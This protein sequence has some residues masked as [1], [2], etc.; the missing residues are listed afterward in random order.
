MARLTD[1][2]TS[3][4]VAS[5]SQL[6]PLRSKIHI[7]RFRS[8]EKEPPHT[9]FQRMCPK[10]NAP[11]A[12]KRRRSTPLSMMRSNKTS[13]ISELITAG[14]VLCKL[15][16]AQVFA[17]GDHV[18]RIC[19]CQIKPSRSEIVDINNTH[20]YCTCDITRVK[21]DSFGTCKTYL[22]LMRNATSATH[23][24]IVITK[25]IFAMFQT[26]ILPKTLECVALGRCNQDAWETYI[27]STINREADAKAV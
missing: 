11:T 26:A 25:G 7:S 15:S 21:K 17:S 20:P 27:R 8:S 5:K 16:R 13:V 6:R 10:S 24:P 3:A 19:G 4:T 9:C 2:G 22:P 14:L 23:T 18:E 1:G 12:L